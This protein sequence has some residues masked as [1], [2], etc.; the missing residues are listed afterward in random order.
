M[1]QNSNNEKNIPIKNEND[2]S[3]ISLEEI[4]YSFTKSGK[5]IKHV[6]Q[7]FFAGDFGVGKSCLFRRFIDGTYKETER[8]T[9]GAEYYTKDYELDNDRTITLKFV[10][11]SGYEL[12]SNKSSSL[13]EGSV[14][15]FVIFDF[16]RIDTFN[17]IEMWKK[18]IDE[19]VHVSENRPIPCILIGNKIDCCKDRKSFKSKEEIEKFVLEYNFINYYEISV[20]EQVNFDEPLRYLIN[21]I[22]DNNIEPLVNENRDVLNN[23][24]ET[25]SSNCFLS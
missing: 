23:E 6:F 22:I 21:Y 3:E 14:G 9:V 4:N 2:T 15:A 13:Y 16:T 1:I 24:T 5:C 8:C 18:D 17:K 10:D 7:I 19:K 25:D 20:K 11:I 12:Y